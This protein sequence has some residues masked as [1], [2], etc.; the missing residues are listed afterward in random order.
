MTDALARWVGGVGG[1]GGGR[2]VTAKHLSGIS[3]E[4]AVSAKS[5]EQ[6]RQALRIRVGIKNE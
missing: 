4:D 5:E 3:S 1:G 2:A 6:G